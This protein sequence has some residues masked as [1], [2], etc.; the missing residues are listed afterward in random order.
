MNDNVYHVEKVP[1]R[2]HDMIIGIPKWIVSWYKDEN[3]TLDDAYLDWLYSQRMPPMHSFQVKQNYERDL[4]FLMCE[5][6]Y[7]ISAIKSLGKYIV[8]DSCGNKF[9]TYDNLYEIVLNE[10]LRWNYLGYESFDKDNVYPDK[11]TKQRSLHGLAVVEPTVKAKLMLETLNEWKRDMFA[12]YYGVRA[13][14][15]FSD[16]HRNPLLNTYT[17]D[18]FRVQRTKACSFE[19]YWVLAGII[20]K[21]RRYNNDREKRKEI[22]RAQYD[23]ALTKL[24]NRYTFKK[25]PLMKKVITLDDYKNHAGIYVLCLSAVRGYYI[26]QASISLSKRIQQHWKKPSSD[27]DRKYSKSDVTAIYVMP[28]DLDVVYGA[29][30]LDIIEQDCI[31]SIPKKYLLNALASAAVL[32]FVDDKR[33]IQADYRISSDVLCDIKDRILMYQTENGLA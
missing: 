23:A 19:F 31:A 18:E 29:Q 22:P 27:F 13:K 4:V 21:F 25:T 9:A 15:S 11:V 30:G 16:L 5:D 26:G 20:K 33:Y 28:L 32:M 12:W 8:Y 14:K 3:I 7:R 10:D 1:I 24:Q 2:W 17:F 6:L